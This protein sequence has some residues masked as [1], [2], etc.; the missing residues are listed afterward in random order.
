MAPRPVA[1][2]LAVEVQRLLGEAKHVFTEL[3]TR[4][5]VSLGEPQL[6]QSGPDMMAW[7]GA[8]GLSRTQ[9]TDQ[10]PTAYRAVLRVHHSLCP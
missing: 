5:V 3:P 10:R 4:H 1:S 7:T 9:S 2:L 6:R 8:I